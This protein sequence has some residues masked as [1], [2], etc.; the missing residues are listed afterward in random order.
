MFWIELC[1][2][3]GCIVIR[4]RVSGIG[5]GLAGGLGLVI[6]VF[7]FRL[8]PTSPPIDVML[9]IMAIITMVSTMHATG[10]MDFL[11]S[12]AERILRRN[13]D[14]ISL[15]APL[16]TYAFTW[17]CGSS[18]VAFSLYPVIAEVAYDA[19]V[20][21]ERPLSI[22]AMAATQAVTAS[23]MSA[24]TAVLPPWSAPASRSAIS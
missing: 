14:R 11:V 6:L 12:M 13:P 15:V 3:L 8:Q 20:R 4:T 21:P 19:R 10:G 9:I 24:A 23:P 1:T 16:V 5:I 7:G 2:V 18:Y 17:F 22:A